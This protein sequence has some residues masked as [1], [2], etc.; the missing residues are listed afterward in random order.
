MLLCKSFWAVEMHK[1]MSLRAHAHI[2]LKSK[3][4]WIAH[5]SDLELLTRWR[6]CIQLS[7]HRM[8][9]GQP[10]KMSLQKTKP[11]VYL[12]SFSFFIH[13]QSLIE[14]IYNLG[15]FVPKTEFFLEN[16]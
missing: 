4:P 12:F 8:I 13:S 9:D 1:I 6:S 5:L 10:L 2:W 16:K 7:S 3:F 15:D 14:S 11:C